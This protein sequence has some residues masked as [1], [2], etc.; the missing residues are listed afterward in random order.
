[1]TSSFGMA[2]TGAAARYTSFRIYITA[3]SGSIVGIREIEFRETPGGPD[4]SS[5]SSAVTASSYDYYSYAPALVVDNKTS[6]SEAY[7]GWLS[8]AQAAPAWVVVTPTGSPLLLK[9]IAIWPMALNGVSEIE[10]FTLQG[11]LD[12]SSWT[13]MKSFSGLVWAGTTPQ[14]FSL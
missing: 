12:G 5:P 8:S 14:T 4:V 1:M 11:S 9:E 3:F 7:T 2:F 13:D 10:A 6:N